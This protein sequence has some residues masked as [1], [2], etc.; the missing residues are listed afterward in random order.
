MAELRLLGLDDHEAVLQVYHDA[1]I[2]QAPGRYSAAQIQAWAGHAARDPQ[3]RL[4]L[5]RGYGLVSLHPS[6]AQRIEAFAL[7]DPGDRL[8]LLYCR[9]SAS[10]QGHGRSLVRALEHHARTAGCPRLRT[11]ASQFSRPL[12]ERLGWQLEAEET[13]LFAG[14]PFVRWRMIRDLL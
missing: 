4:A 6:E 11:E 9:G 10:R 14:E 7:L 8:S 12:L 3:V 5:R 1:V 2:S 13:V